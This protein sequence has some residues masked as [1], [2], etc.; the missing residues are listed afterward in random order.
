MFSNYELI[1]RCPHGRNHP[2]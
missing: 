1:R 2:N